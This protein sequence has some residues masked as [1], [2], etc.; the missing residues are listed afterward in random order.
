MIR[1]V[2]VAIIV[3]V[4]AVMFLPQ[5]VTVFPG[6]DSVIGT[7]ASDLGVLRD[8]IVDRTQD[9]VS[10]TLGAVSGAISGAFSR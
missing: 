10:R 8:G 1:I 7:A 4:G 3:A 6:V 2:I 5:T 9:T